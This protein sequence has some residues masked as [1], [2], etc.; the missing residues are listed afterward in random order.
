MIPGLAEYV[1]ARLVRRHLF[2]AKFLARFGHFL[3][4]YRANANQSN[5]VQV[6]DAYAGALARLGVVGG[7]SPNILEIG[8]GATNSVG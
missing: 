4:H 5:P 8:S 2:S 1:L 3:P 7:S 6:V